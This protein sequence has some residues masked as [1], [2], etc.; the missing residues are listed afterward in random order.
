M[1]QSLFENLTN[2]FLDRTPIAAV[3][4]DQLRIKSIMDHLTRLFNTRAESL[5]HTAGYGLPDISEVYRTMPRGIAGFQK[6]IKLVIDKFEPRIRNVKV[7]PLDN[8][9]R[10]FRL[11]FILSGELCGGGKVQFQTTFTSS[12]TSSIAPWK[13][14]E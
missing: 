5:P 13:K 3:P 1:K 10:D 12:G 2:E 9:E 4:Q 7:V 8:A 11:V 14:T 6:A